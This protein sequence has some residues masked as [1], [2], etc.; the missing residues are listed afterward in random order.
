MS[1]NI[2]LCCDGTANEFK[3]DRTNVV[4]L[5]STL[6]KDRDHQAAF[7]HAGIGTMAPPGALSRTSAFI[8]QTAG[9]AF[10]YG[11]QDDI[12]DAYVFIINNFDSGDKVFLFGFS[13]GAYTVRALAS[14]LYMYGVIGKG[15]EPLVPYAIRML[16]AIHSLK[17]REK[18]GVTVENERKVRDYF[19]LACEFKRTFSV[20]ECNPHFVGIW[21]TVSSIGWIANPLSLPY[22]ASNPAIQVGRHAIAIDE[23]RAFFR[24]NLWTPSL[25]SGNGGPK[26]MKQIWFPGVHGDVGGGYPESESGLSKIALQWML[27]EGVANDLLI[28]EK[29]CALVLG[30]NGGGYARPDPKAKLHKSLTVPWWVAEFVPKLHWN[31]ERQSNEWRMNLFGRRNMGGAP[32]VHRSAKDRGDE[33]AN[34]LPPEATFI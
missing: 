2:V 18:D 14:L 13:R 7:Y 10:G 33:Y 27:E 21:D 26:D 22:T 20:A 15:N 32:V 29:K 24:S 6:I 5:F 31:D 16:W 11:L 28:D 23:R 25:T 9:L 19:D 8:A 4:K 1:K 3:R 17:K 12:R 34:R 30:Y